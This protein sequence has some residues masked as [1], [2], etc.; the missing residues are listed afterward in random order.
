V[1]MLQHTPG[2]WLGLGVVAL[3]VGVF[4]AIFGLSL[5][6]HR[7]IALLAL[8]FFAIGALVLIAARRIRGASPPR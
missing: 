2:L 3:A 7:S 5:P 8:P 1:R 6:S 4:V